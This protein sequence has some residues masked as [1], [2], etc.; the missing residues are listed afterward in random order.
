MPSGEEAHEPGGDEHVDEHADDVVGDGDEGA[1]G[2]SGID[3]EAFESEG[4]EGAE[5]RCKEHH[6]HQR[7]RYGQGGGI[8]GGELKAVVDEYEKGDYKAVDETYA[9]FLEDLP[10]GLLEV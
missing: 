10:A 3:F 1:G 8:P 7:E 5:Y 6:S 9:Y 2:E 4:Y